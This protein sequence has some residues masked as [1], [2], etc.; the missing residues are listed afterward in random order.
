M[1]ANALRSW[2]SGNSLGVR[3]GLALTASIALHVTVLLPAS[4]WQAPP[5]QPR[6]IPPS[7]VLRATLPAAALATYR[8]ESAAPSMAPA[9]TRDITPTITPNPVHAAA[10]NST[11][12]VPPAPTF[13]REAPKPLQ[14]H[15][16]DTA[17]AALTREE[18]YPR[19]A[20]EQGIEGRVVLLL[21][22]SEAGAVTA[23]DIASTSGYT[24]LDQ[25]ARHAASRIGT[26]PGTSR[27]V[28]LPVAFQLD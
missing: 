24:V 17:L 12:A 25:A 21:T 14:R 18:F 11:V 5:R 22:V 3:L 10:E 4:R 26:L 15:T 6:A 23:I 8:G 13:K 1:K 16:L 9:V 20:I 2:R 7:P 28:L 27:Q 19:A